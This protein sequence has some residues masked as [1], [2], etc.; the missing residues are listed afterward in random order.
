M[1]T[2]IGLWVL[3]IA[4]VAVALAID[5]GLHGYRRE[6]GISIPEAG[7]WTIFWVSLALFFAGVVYGLK[8]HARALEFL[9][10]YLI[11]ES[12][13]VDNMFVFVM[14]FQFFKITAAEQPRI[15]KWGILGAIV[16]RF[17]LI[18][19]GVSLVQ[20]YHW[21]LYVFGILLIATALKMAFD[22]EEDTDP[23]K[24]FVI[25]FFQ[26]LEQKGGW[27][28]TPFWMIILVVEASDL[29]FALDSIPA[30]LAISNDPFIVFTSNIFAVLG[31][32][33]LFFMISGFIHVFRF[34]R[35]RQSVFLI[36]I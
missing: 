20:R 31:L 34:L 27:L 6:E 4:M 15:L 26:S 36:F 7:R 25:R 3:F 24:N 14:I 32:R 9:T 17:V 19:S 13:S 28:V 33:A 2:T 5:L 8:G 12:L 10:G 21:V 1:M 23:E 35:Y 30:V 16:M 11:E 29:I 18:F 22:S